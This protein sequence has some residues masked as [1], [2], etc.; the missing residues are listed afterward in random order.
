M[1][2]RNKAH[3]K[4]NDGQY[5][6]LA[7]LFLKD[8]CGDGSSNVVISPLSILILLA[9]ASVSTAGKTRTEIVK[10]LGDPEAEARYSLLLREMAGDKSISVSNAISVREDIAPAVRSEYAKK[11]KQFFDGEL[12]CSKDLVQDINNWVEKKTRGMIREI[13]TDDMNSMIMA[14]IN[15]V[16]FESSW[17][18]PY[19]DYA[20]LDQDFHN[21]DGT[22]SKVYMMHGS[23][24]IYLEDRDFTGFM[25]EYK[26]GSF[27]YMAL[28]PKKKGLKNLLDALDRV[29][30]MNLIRSSTHEEVHTRL[31]EYRI[32]FQ[33]NL[34]P[35]I[36]SAGVKEV[37]T[38][39]ADFSPMAT[40]PL[41][42]ETVLHKA[43]IE[44]DRSGTRA[45][46]VT[47]GAMVAGCL[48]PMDYKEVFLD[49]PF[50]F[51]IIHKA[52]ELPLFAGVVTHL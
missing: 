17:A 47:L 12:F 19:E 21:A 50:V 27:S 43:Y 13:A 1:L 49:R 45:A 26:G 44:V 38:D 42:L 7:R 51:A 52:T 6:A 46:A 24:S 31:P 30:Y 40:V 5:N 2:S 16:A 8:C 20:V 11:M 29:D 28:L 23:E 41:K 10:L 37:F 9:M 32:G 35:L 39:Q 25:K 34:V 15:A 4:A 48:P 36:S 3:S 14:L 18:E 33:Q 22:K